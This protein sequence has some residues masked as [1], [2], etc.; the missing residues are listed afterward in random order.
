VRRLDLSRDP[1]SGCGGCP[2]RRGRRELVLQLVALTFG[3]LDLVERLVA[4]AFRGFDQGEGFVA[5]AFG[6]F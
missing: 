3:G 1:S 4:L 6:G 5:L 2:I